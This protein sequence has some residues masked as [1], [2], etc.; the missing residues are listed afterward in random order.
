M[1]SVSLARPI[2]ERVSVPPPKLQLGF[3][4]NGMLV[5]GA[6]VLMAAAVFWTARGP[7]LE[8][9]DFTF[10]YLGARLVLQG[11]GARL[12]DLS[13]QRKLAA[14]LFQ[15][16]NPL[17][18][19]HPPF[20]ALVFA[21]LATLPYR[22]A[23]VIW[24]LINAVIS[25]L[26]LYL[27]RPYAPFPRS[28]G[29]YL[30]AW[31]FFAPL[32][33]ALCEG[34]SSLALLLLYILTFVNLRRGRDLMAGV[35]LGL[36][37]FKFQFVLPFALILLLRRKW[38]FAGGFALSAALLSAMSLIPAG[39]RGVSN[40][41]SLLLQI[42]RHPAHVSFGS[43]VDMPTIQ[44]FVYAI[45][46]RGVSSTAISLIVALASVV[47]IGL[48]AWCWGQVDRISNSDSGFDLM[49]AG[50]VAVSLM[51]GF[52]MF[53]HD[54]SPLLLAMLL[55]LAHFPGE[56]RRR[57]RQL[58][59]ATLGIFWAWPIYFVLVAWHSLYLML[60]VLLAF[61]MVAIRLATTQGG[62]LT[63]GGEALTVSQPV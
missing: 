56:D 32:C 45:L 20:E 57:P 10:T 2:A 43:A 26:A 54:F 5:V 3:S 41:L 39:W 19:E 49:F 44:G 23:Y 18:Y 36:G 33:V 15:H 21:P 62:P 11:D 14:S 25:L 16:P 29:G 61:A 30:A 50:A 12:Y 48:T 52:H 53:T 42:S 4:E 31:V 38:R 6:A 55:V 7:F 34:Q 46:H 47:L 40:Y 1:G 27:V 17:I 58:L 51:T 22:T 28:Q 8:K 13:E 35:F 60:P 24:G 9:T 37:L 59:K 63:N